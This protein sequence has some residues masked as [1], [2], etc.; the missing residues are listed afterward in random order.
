MNE[1]ISMLDG[2]GG[3]PIISVLRRQKQEIPKASCP[4]RIDNL[5]SS[6]FC[7]NYLII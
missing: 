4:I 1:S 7:E 6:G 5:G 2:Y 3:P